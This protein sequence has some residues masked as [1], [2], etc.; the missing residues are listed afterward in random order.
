[1][2]LGLLAT[3][4]LMAALIVGLVGSA[5]A[6]HVGGIP[7]GIPE[8]GYTLVYRLDIPVESHYKLGPV[9]YAIDNS[10]SIGSF[11]RIAYFL[12]IDDGSGLQWVYVSMDAFTSV[13]AQ[14][15]VPIAP[16]GATFQQTVSNMNVFS[17]V[18]GIVTGTGI[19][20]GNIEFWH[21]RYLEPVTLGLPGA[22]DSI[23]P[24]A[25]YGSMQVHN[26]GAGVGQTIFAYNY[27]DRTGPGD[28]LGIGNSPI[29]PHPDWI[30]RS[31]AGSYTVKRMDILVGTDVPLV[32]TLSQW[33]LF[34]MAVALAAVML[35]RLRAVRRLA[36]TRS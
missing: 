28:D 22:S 19:T 7:P 32:P 33:G 18:P 9:P 10:A 26:H 6:S 16:T 24:P 34:A 29:G 21:N 25:C 17:N 35:W 4:G 13:P 30:F 12:E 11:D 20:T 31:N 14:I 23:C 3:L 27:W 15:G 5:S 36:R 2:A 1:M 8:P